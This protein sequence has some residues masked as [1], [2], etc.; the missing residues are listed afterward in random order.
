MDSIIEGNEERFKY[1]S[2]DEYNSMI[3][4]SR[5]CIKPRKK[6]TKKAG[7]VMSSYDKNI[8]GQTFYLGNPND[9]IDE[10]S[11]RD[12]ESNKEIDYYEPRRQ[13]RNKKPF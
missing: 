4:D 6:I 8:Q 10:D 2:A 9:S 1:E 3:R 11:E 7:H 12:D 13:L 5:M